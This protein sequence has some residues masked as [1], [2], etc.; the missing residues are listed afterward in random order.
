MKDFH[1][2]K[3]D[4]A[5]HFDLVKKANK[6]RLIWTWFQIVTTLIFKFDAKY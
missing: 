3:L 4:V 6:G 5:K 2:F 1:I